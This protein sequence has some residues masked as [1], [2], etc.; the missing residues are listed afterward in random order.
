MGCNRSVPERPLNP[1]EYEIKRLETRRQPH[2]ASTP[3]LSKTVTSISDHFKIEKAIGTTST[4][5]MLYAR[6]IKSGTYRAIREVKKSMVANSP[7]I[8]SEILILTELDHPNIIKIFQ[9]IETSIN[10]YIVYEYL[11]G[12]TLNTKVRRNGNELI[13]SK[14][15]HEVI[16]AVF[17][18]HIRGFI[19]CDLN[20]QN[21]LFDTAGD[22][23]VP[24]IVGFGSAQNITNK[25]P[26]DMKKISYIY[27]SPDILKNEYDEKTDMWSI[28]I[29]V[30]E[31][32]VG[33][34]PYLSKDKHDIL[35]EIYKGQVDLEN[36]VFLGLSFNAQDFLKKLLV[37]SPEERL[38]S[39]EALEHPWIAQASKEDYVNYEALQKL[40]TFKVITI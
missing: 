40:R 15:M 6:D 36:S 31:L 33:K 24:K 5:T 21:I 34:H 37:E 14:Y 9:T 22:E 39:K 4:G 32:L 3:L 25:E 17:Y 1:K 8:S 12:G 13:V 26:F 20:P 19:H 16:S 30:Y 23:P 35:R 7:I 18:M 2:T 27:T 11:D 28:G 38:S 10:Y 29:M